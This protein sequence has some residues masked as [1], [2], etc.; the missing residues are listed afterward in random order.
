MGGDIDMRTLKLFFVAL[1]PL[2]LFARPQDFREAKQEMIEIY[3]DL[4]K[5]SW[6]EFYCNAPF[7]ITKNNKLVVIDSDRF[8]PRETRSGKPNKRDRFIEWEHIVPMSVVY[9]HFPCWRKGGRKEC[10]RSDKKFQL[11]EAD[12]QNLKPSIGSINGDRSNYHYAEAPRNAVFS[13]YGNCQVFTDFKNKTFYPA[14]YSKG[15]I[16][17]TYLY[18]SEEYDIRLSDKERK[19]MLAWNKQYPMTKDER[20]F[21]QTIS[22]IM[23]IDFFSVLEK[24]LNDN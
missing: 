1:L 10:Q 24:A 20:Y 16:A 23:G 13:Q 8:S 3:K 2:L 7:K 17:R 18:M 15:Y 22:R 21:R 9:H 5:S 12:M 6:F 4:G 19:L 14:N 11:L